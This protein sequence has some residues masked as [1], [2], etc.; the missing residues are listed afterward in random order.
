MACG[1]GELKFV[2]MLEDDE[3][4]G[5]EELG[6]GEKFEGAGV[7]DVGRVGRIDEDEIE[8]CVGLV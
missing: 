6:G 3:G 8:G 1:F 2:M 7:V 5:S 4:G